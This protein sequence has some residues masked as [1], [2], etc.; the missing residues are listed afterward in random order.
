MTI[1]QPIAEPV[2]SAIISPNSKS[3][4]AT[5]YFCTY[6]IAIPNMDDRRKTRKK[7]HVTPEIFEELLKYL[8]HSHTCTPNKKVWM[9]LSNEGR[10]GPFGSS[11]PGMINKI[12]ITID[13]KRAG[14]IV[15]S[16]FF[17]IIKQKIRLASHL[18]G[19]CFG[20]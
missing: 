11:L 6:S 8:H 1:N 3:L 9:T 4:L 12:K 17:V 14:Q 13:H 16:H 7:N 2:I 18:S 15:L 10:S 20:G 19:V 5:K